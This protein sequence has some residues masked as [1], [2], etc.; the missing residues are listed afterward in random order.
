[1]LT[2]QYIHFYNQDEKLTIYKLK[3][4]YDMDAILYR[5]GRYYIQDFSPLLIRNTNI[6]NCY[7]YDK[8]AYEL[9]K[10][11]FINDYKY[12]L[13]TYTAIVVPAVY[14]EW[15]YNNMNEAF[16]YINLISLDF[17]IKN[18]IL[19]IMLWCGFHNYELIE[20]FVSKYPE[21][22]NDEL[23]KCLS[24][25]DFE[26]GSLIKREKIKILNKYDKQESCENKASCSQCLSQRYQHNLLTNIC[27]CKTYIHYR[28]VVELISIGN[29]ICI[30]CRTPIKTNKKVNSGKKTIFFPSIQFYNFNY[31]YQYVFEIYDQLICAIMYYQI[32]EF[33]NIYNIISDDDFVQFIVNAESTVI[34]ECKNENKIILP[35]IMHQT[36]IEK[37]QNIDI[38]LT[39]EKYLTHKYMELD[40]VNMD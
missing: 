19:K 3:Y 12:L 39:I 33:I 34:I 2:E 27:E 37:E 4:T 32:D 14:K 16:E 24:Y 17:L 29:N 1:M 30:R 38:A 22:I 36:G 18:E 28:C 6:N 15:T 7:E 20:Y 25:S 11:N 23:Y 31:T 40:I 13:H 5:N 35:D 9:Y 8:I 21:L 26:F 10:N